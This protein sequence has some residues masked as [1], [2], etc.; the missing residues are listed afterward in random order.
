V[1]AKTERQYLRL[2]EYMRHIM[3]LGAGRVPAE[4]TGSGDVELGTRREELGVAGDR[5]GSRVE[6]GAVG[7]AH[8]ECKHPFEAYFVKNRDNCRQMW[9]A[10]ERENACTLGNNTNNRLESSWKQLEEL[11]DS[12]MQVDECIVPIMVYQAQ[13]ERKFLDAVY[14]L[15]VVHNPKYRHEMEF[16]SKL[17]SEHACEFVYEQYN[18]ATTTPK[19]KFHEAVPGVYLIQCDADDEDALDEPRS[20]YSVTKSNWSCSC[21]FMAS[22]LLPYRHV[23]FIRRALNFENVIPTQ[24]LDTRWLLSSLRVESELPQLSE[25][26]FRVS[27]VLKETTTAWDSNRKFRDAKFVASSISERLS[28]L[29]MVEYR[30]AME[31]LRGVARL[32]KH[33]EYSIIPEVAGAREREGTLT[34]GGTNRGG[35]QQTTDSEAETAVLEVVQAISSSQV[36]TASPSVASASSVVS[37]Q[38]CADPLSEGTGDDQSGSVGNAISAVGNEMGA[39]DDEL[40]LA[41]NETGSGDD[42]LGAEPAEVVTR[43]DE[44]STESEAPHKN[45]NGS[46]LALANLTEDFQIMSPPKSKGRPKQKSRA[47]K[48]KRNQAVAMV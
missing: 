6:L 38:V 35:N 18:F 13:A 8:E 43:A 24:L 47:V 3:G 15:S 28:G 9:C 27:R 20:E 5:V 17:V 14:K 32:F 26:P 30:A 29:G 19:Y 10:F 23:F 39:G 25:E 31:A 4:S 45:D 42:E 1:Y 12:F 40:G 11:V 33:G 16:L 48:A 22:R 2:R 46:T 37:T 44:V 41:G 34:S 21:L 7:E 36:A